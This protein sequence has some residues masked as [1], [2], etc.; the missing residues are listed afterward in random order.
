MNCAVFAFPE[1]LEAAGRLARDLG[2]E[3]RPV[4]VRQFPDGESLVRVPPATQTALLYRSL[5]RPNDKI[6]ELLLAASALREGGTSRLVLV[7]PYLAYMRQDRA[8]RTGEAISQQVLGRLLAEYCDALIT[9][10]PH[11]HRIDTLA[12]IMPGIEAISVTAAPALSGALSTVDNPILVG[13]DSE[14]RQWVEA[15][16]RPGGLSFLVGEKRRLDDRTVDLAI[17]GAGQ[18]KGRHVVLVDDLLSSGTTLIAA[19]DLVSRAGAR[20]VTA[21]V[22]HCLASAEDLRRLTEAGI[23]SVRATD[24]VPCDLAR[25]PISEVLA[26]AIR[27]RIGAAPD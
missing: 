11:L 18:A 5:D 19:A 26:D 3:C 22:T 6:F 17:P 1:S 23:S 27:N 4:S 14:S 9:V 2:I 8:F 12:D 7:V 20:S 13:P 15:I 21:L 24:T 25:I 16:A 10:D